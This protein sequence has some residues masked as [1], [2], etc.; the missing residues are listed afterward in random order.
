MNKNL[1]V[2]LAAGLVSAVSTQAQST[3]YSAFLAYGSTDPVSA[4]V[5]PGIEPGNVLTYGGSETFTFSITDTTISITQVGDST[6]GNGVFNG[7]VL[8]EVSGYAITGVSLNRSSTFPGLTAG[9]VSFS[10][11]QITVNLKGLEVP[12]ISTINLDVTT[13]PEPTTLALAGL[14]AAAVMLRKRK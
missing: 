3:Y 11:N 5:G 13:V 12:S 1:A 10:A 7:W 8:N 2:L 6:Y 4:Y 14:G 9:R